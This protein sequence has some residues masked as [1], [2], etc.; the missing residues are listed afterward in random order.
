M[1]AQIDPRGRLEKHGQHGAVEANADLE[2]AIRPDEISQPRRETSKDEAA[3]RQAGHEGRQYRGDRIDR[4]PEDEPEHAEP[5]DLID[6][7]GRTGEEKADPDQRESGCAKP[8]DAGDST[9]RGA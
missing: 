5:D 2:P 8:H 1:Q 9:I 6:E 3:E 7:T 4:V